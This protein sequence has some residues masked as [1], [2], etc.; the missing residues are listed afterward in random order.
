MGLAR[1]SPRHTALFSLRCSADSGW[2]RGQRLAAR[3]TLPRPARVARV[4]RVAILL[5]V[6]RHVATLDEACGVLCA[7][8]HVVTLDE[9]CGGRPLR[10]VAKLVV[11]GRGRTS[12]AL[13][14]RAL[15]RRALSRRALSRRALSHLVETDLWNNVV[16]RAATRLCATRRSWCPDRGNVEPDATRG[17]AARRFAVTLLCDATSWLSGV[18]PDPPC[19][20]RRRTYTCI[21]TRPPREI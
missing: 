16:R 19:H 10:D 1:V 5:C 3:V 11:R 20:T 18:G 13:S 6:T 7:T 8:R 12:L 9:A 4:A 17:R 21:R 14:R 15:S 2:N